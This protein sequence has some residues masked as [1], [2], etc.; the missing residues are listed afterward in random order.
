MNKKSAPF[1]ALFF[2]RICG[3]VFEYN[4]QPR[5]ELILLARAPGVSPQSS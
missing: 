3:E 4:D 1:G 5:I 2:Y